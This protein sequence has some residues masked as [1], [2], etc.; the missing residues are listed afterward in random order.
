[1]H[2]RILGPLEILDDE[3]REVALD[4]QRLRAL[5]CR[6]L[7]D[8]GHVVPAETLVASLWGDDA[9]PGA[10]G[11]VQTYVTRLR[12]VLEPGR[13]ARGAASMLL[14]R[15]AGYVISLDHSS[16]DAVEMARLVRSGS[17]ALTAGGATTA[18]SLL[19][20]ARALWRGRPFHDVADQPWALPA[21]ARLTQLHM[22]AIELHV[23]AWLTLGD[24]GTAIGE[25]ERHVHDHPLHERYW[26]Q[27]ITGLYRSGRQSD[28][29]RAYGRCREILRQELGVDPG[30][31]LQALERA[32]LAHDPTLDL[33]RPASSP[34]ED[35]L[36]T[37]STDATPANVAA[38]VAP[39][40]PFVGRAK[41]REQVLEVFTGA[42]ADRGKIVV[43][44]G[45]AGIGKTR[46]AEAKAE[47]AAAMGMAVAWTVCLDEIGAPPL[48]PWLQIREQI[49]DGSPI[50]DHRDRV[51]TPGSDNES[52]LFRELVRVVDDLV[53]AS[54]RRPLVAIIDDMQWADQASLQLLRLL[55]GRL[56]DAPIVVIA[57]VRRPDASTNRLLDATLADLVRSPH[58]LRIRLAGL[59]PQ[60][61]ADLVA[62]I[63]GGPRA[64]LT[65]TLHQ[66]TRGNPFFLS[67]TAKL[68]AA[69]AVDSADL[70][71]APVADLVPDTV[72]EVVERRVHRLPD[73]TQTMLR[74]TAMAGS[75]IELAV[76]QHATG[77]DAEQAIALLEPAVQAGLLVELDDAIGWR[78]DHALA[79]DA[80]RATIARTTRARLH[81]TLATS[82]EHVH[83]NDLDAHLDEL[84]HHSHEG[85]PVAGKASALAWSLAAASAAH[86]RHGYDRA[87]F[88]WGR[89]LDLSDPA[90]SSD[91]FELL[92]SLAEDLRL[93]GDPEA[94]RVRLEQAIAL[95]R[96]IGDDERAARAAVVFGGVTLGYWRPYG[97]V[98]WSMVDE[99]E[100]LAASAAG[101]PSA[102]SCTTATAAP[103]APEPPNKQSNSPASRAT[104]HCSVGR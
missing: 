36:P 70:S 3:Q 26:G 9:P 7:L 56:A 88:H 98:E 78:F 41:E 49:I 27:L 92:L 80:V 45:E 35:R 71:A 14:T 39:E 82:I 33:P 57:T 51:L 24:H 90:D 22:T 8:P 95:A 10:S 2:F 42:A 55:S 30:P 38:A 44:E 31:E 34:I 60:E 84:A 65:D 79:Q 67:E 53:A 69:E 94:A 66:R 43:I 76:L 86:R 12:R 21:V 102:S 62:T 19:A 99:V 13:Q 77:L 91:R 23:D 15:P 28:A 25:L 64:Q 20:T 93:M 87:A 4:S 47:H 75:G 97:V 61:S 52:G 46:L 29:L 50:A 81:A 1:V 85:A 83:T 104:L 96:R 89:A 17:E 40:R 16:L 32:V 72:R 48:W 73:D 58:H 63:A 59:T 101:S 6:L 68:L 18:A 37:A 54:Q 5:V 74:L 11:T 103:T 100:R